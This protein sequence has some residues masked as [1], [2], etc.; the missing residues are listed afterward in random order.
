[1]SIVGISG[2]RNEPTPLQAE[3]IRLAIAS[4]PAG[5]MVVTGACIGVDAL[6][7]RIAFE[8]GLR[9]FTVVPANRRMVDPDW[10]QY[11]HE[12]HIMPAW[13]TYRDRNEYIV[14]LCEWL[15]A[16]PQHGEHDKASLRSGTWQTIRIARRLGKK[17]L[18]L[19]LGDIS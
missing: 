14:N 16:F 4:L 1:M 17:T 15:L 7:A 5:T 10:Q 2:S 6:V 19:I 18:A 9:V 11:C 13:T 8:I 12:Y 3:R